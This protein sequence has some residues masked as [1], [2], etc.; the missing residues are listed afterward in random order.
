[1]N[2][3]YCILY[4]AFGLVLNLK[5]QSPVKPMWL[6]QS[7]NEENRL[8]MHASFYS[9][10]NERA[11]SAGDLR[12]SANYQSLNGAWKFKWVEAPA[13]LPEHFEA[14]N[15]DDHNWDNFTIPATWEVNGY[16]YP[17][18]TNIGY[19]FQDLLPKPFDPP[20]VPLNY[21]PTGVYRREI[22]VAPAWSG[23]N[24]VLHIGSAKS[25]VQAWI[26]G[27]YAGYSE[28]SKLAAEFDIT[29]LLKPGKNL[30]VLK[31]MRW[32]DGTYLEGQDFWRMGGVMRDCYLVARNPLHIQDFHLVTK[33]DK[34]C[35]QATLSIKVSLS[36]APES[37][38]NALVEVHDGG[39]LV[40]SGRL[41]FKNSEAN[42]IYLKIAH[43]QLW[44]A[45]V[46]KLYKVTLKLLDRKYRLLEVIPQAIGFR[47]VLIRNGAL[48]VNGKPILIKGINRHETDPV[49]G[50]TISRQAMLHDILLMKQ[51][52][53]NAVRTSHYPNDEYWYELCDKYGLYVVDEA[54]I[55]SHGLGF[56]AASLAKHPDWQTAHLQRV[57]RLFERDKNHTS[58]IIWSM[59]NEAG[60]GINFYAAYR[61]LKARDFTRPVQ[62]EGAVPD[63]YTMKDDF[64]T[65]IINPM[66]PS[67]DQMRAYAQQHP[68][69]DKPFI[70]CEYA[71][72]MGNS[73]G[74]FKDYWELI[75]S[76]KKH[77]QGGF[78]WDFVDQ[79]LQKIN[80]V[81][82]TIY[83]YGGDYGPANV[84]SD[85]N[86]L[87]NGIFYPNRNPNPH[88]WEMKQQYQNIHTTLVP[89]KRG[90][91]A[92]Y[93]ENFF[94]NLSYAMMRWEVVVNG[95]IR[96]TGVIKNLAVPPQQTKI[97]R[98]KIN[99]PSD[100]ETYLNI[101]YLQ[102]RQESLVPAQHVLAREQ[103][104]LSGHYQNVM[105]L[106]PAGKIRLRDTAIMCQISSATAT[107]RFNKAT[108]YL[109]Q[110]RV[111]DQN[112]MEE[113]IG[114][115]PNFWRPPTDNDMGANLQLTLK[116]W[117]T[118]PRNTKLTNF[119]VEQKG[120]IV[121]VKASYILPDVSAKLHL[122]YTINAAG[123]MLV[124]QDLL[125]DTTEYL[126][127][128]S[129]FGMKWI[130][131]AGFE[132]IAY[133]GRGPDE[134]YQD[135]QTAYPIGRYQQTVKQQYYPYIRPQE[136]GNKTDIRWFALTNAAGSG[137]M[138][139]SDRWLSMSALHYLDSDLDD[140]DQKHQRHAGDLKARAQTQLNIDYKQ[141]GLGGTNSWG[142]LPLKHYTL[143]YQNYSYQFKVVPI[144]K[145]R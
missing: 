110:Y 26:N 108:G 29:R 96:Q 25:N 104:Y 120:A 64:D 39:L 137:I 118:A 35:Q 95:E 12:Q 62:Y 138:I 144:K 117:K 28:D 7:R 68:N 109:D 76:N 89:G 1:M 112:L 63:S 128:L 93:N 131:P 106:K 135:R 61:W 32:S 111:N 72:A 115:Q 130:L 36:K 15:F 122:Q 145:N 140:G 9:F 3:R 46:P 80:A 45:E 79:G 107:L 77:F 67:P 105:T 44:S 73:L 87:C 82:D 90:A 23:R 42:E 60:N 34:D 5:A 132:S 57:Q 123:E 38:V 18:Y 85:N 121:T 133:Y 74:N 50:Q 116:A 10:E 69:P 8:P 65:D 14:V 94:K 6:D 11:A 31:V 37:P 142:A 84:P 55:E 54:N 125:A 48:L 99:L 97:Y 30:M 126:K 100:G 141:M 4:L 16:G 70:M 75:R 129:R 40:A 43:P 91:V 134:N 103:L 49:T 27:Q 81:G 17:I 19:E 21:D 56:G 83:A 92:V 33:L 143:P 136:T 102:K 119:A 124:K 13:E 114:L 71:H 88:A 24:I 53:I 2:K 22:M 98:L 20:N 58:V 41:R 52:N 47:Q 78:I 127:M 66:Y 59:G 86:F 51:Y 101:S 139:C 113:G